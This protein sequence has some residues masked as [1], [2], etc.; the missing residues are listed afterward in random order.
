ML[1][2][3]E[4]ST[5]EESFSQLLQT[6]NKQYKIAVTVQTGYKGVFKNTNKINEFYLKTAFDQ[7][8]STSIKKPVR[9]YKLE[10][11]NDEIE[12]N[13]VEAAPLTE[14]NYAI[15]FKPVFLQF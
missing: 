9:P 8:D 3:M 13:T 1:L 2:V 7:L 15:L 6:N 10:N 5:H 14:A 11:L 4:K 12:R